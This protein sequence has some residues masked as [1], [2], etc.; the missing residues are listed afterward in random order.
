MRTFQQE[1]SGTYL[2]RFTSRVGEIAH[3]RIVVY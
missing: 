1:H 3:E 2:L